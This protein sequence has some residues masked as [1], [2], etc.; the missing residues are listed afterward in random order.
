[1]T[2]YV[3]LISLASDLALWRVK[4][5]VQLI[6]RQIYVNSILGSYFFSDFGL[7]WACQGLLLI[8]ESLR[9]TSHYEEGY[10]TKLGMQ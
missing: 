4:L 8:L 9:M 10:L 2:F 6:G 7:G 1:M 3:S 5:C